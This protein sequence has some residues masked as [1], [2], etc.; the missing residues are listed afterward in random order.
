MKIDRYGQVTIPN[1]PSWC[2]R[3]NSGGNATAANDYVGWTSNTSG[4]SSKACHITGVTL[5]GSVSGIHNA[6]SSG[7]LTVP[8]SGKY[9]IWVSIRGENMPGVGNLYIDV[10]GANVARQ[11]VEVWGPTYGYPFGTTFIEL[12]LNLSANDYIETRIACTGLVVA[13]FVDNVNWFAGHL[14]G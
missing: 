2:L 7:R 13:G 6:T 3:P 10:N 1:Q 14:I 5:T 8:V 12:V 11:H 9:K 4:S